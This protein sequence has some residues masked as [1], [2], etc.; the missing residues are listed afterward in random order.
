MKKHLLSICILLCISL[1]SQAQTLRYFE[2]NTSCGYNETRDNS[3]I[4][5][6]SNTD[7]INSVLAEIAKPIEERKF[8]NGPIDFGNGGHNKNGSYWFNWHFIPDQWELAD[9]ATEVCD[10]CPYTDVELNT[11][12]WVN[13]VKYFCPW[14]G[15]PI[16]EV[17][18]PLNVNQSNGLN[19][20][21]FYPN[22]AKKNIYFKWNTQDGFKV[23]LFD[24][25]GKALKTYNLTKQ[26]PTI[27]IT[28]LPQ[29]IYFMKITKQHQTVVKKLIIM[30]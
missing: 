19:N 29:G 21:T 16:Q 11:N 26:Q 25:S 24:V 5:A 8:I 2:F 4:A 22:P 15:K 28:S 9:S 12:Y 23:E 10:G 1:H 6:T 3:F 13:T 7:L 30:H 17:S 27:N 18:E 20:L 14:S